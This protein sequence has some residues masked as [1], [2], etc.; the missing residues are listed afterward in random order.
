MITAL[1]GAVINII[2]NFI[3][4]PDHGAMGAAVA[5]FISYLAVYTVRAYDTRKFVKFDLHTL[6]LI[7][8]IALIFLQMA[9]MYS[10]VRYSEYIALLMILV[11][12][13]VNLRGIIS[14][15]KEFIK[16][17]LKKLKKGK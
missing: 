1:M 4:I 2:L 7:I 5:T 12:V 13:A 15:V 16:P 6:L 10:G 9:V 17:L 8:N 14:V 11:I 3:M